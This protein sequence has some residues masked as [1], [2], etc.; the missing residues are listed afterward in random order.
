[1]ILYLHVVLLLN[2]VREGNTNLHVAQVITIP[3][4]LVFRGGQVFTC[5]PVYSV[6]YF[7][8]VVNGNHVSTMHGF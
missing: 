1:M 8:L 6:Y 2:C 3:V 4:P 7:L 5:V